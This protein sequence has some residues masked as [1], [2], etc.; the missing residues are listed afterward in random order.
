[1]ASKVQKNRSK[2]QN[3][4]SGLSLGPKGILFVGILVVLAMIW[5]FVL[6]IFVGRG[7]DPREVVPEISRILPDPQKEEVQEILTPE[8]L[9]FLENLRKDPPGGSRI[10]YRQTDPLEE[11]RENP[12]PE[13]LLDNS[14]SEQLMEKQQ[15]QE[16]TSQTREQKTQPPAPQEKQEKKDEKQSDEDRYIYTFQ[17]GS[18]QTI[19]KAGDLQQK[20]ADQG[21]KASITDAYIEGSPW[22]RVLVEFQAVD[23][24]AKKLTSKLKR[25][26]IPEPLL[27]GKKGL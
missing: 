26:G 23:Y 4:Q 27:V 1:M 19:D 2:K 15:V 14:E 11:P 22:Y 8:E 13:Q 21:L 5:S 25:H 20:L 16:K 17:V 3:T 10:R 6:G 7:H 9:E 12:E 24:S 18:F